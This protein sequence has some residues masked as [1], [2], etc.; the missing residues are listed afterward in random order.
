MNAD[1]FNGIVATG[2]GG[3]F[4]NLMRFKSSAGRHSLGMQDKFGQIVH[5]EI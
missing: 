1:G 4:L 3:G 2:W 5:L